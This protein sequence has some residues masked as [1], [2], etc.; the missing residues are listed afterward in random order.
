MKVSLNWIKEFVDLPADLSIQQLAYDLTMRTVEVEGF[1]DLGASLDKIVV[2]KIESVEPHP[3]QA[4]RLRVVKVDAGEDELCQV[5]CGGSNL[6]VGQMVVLAKPGSY[7]RWHGEGEPVEIKA[8]KL[9]GV[10]SAGMI[11]ASAEIGMEELFPAKEEAEIVDLA[12]YDATPGQP[13]SKLV[14]RDDI[15]LRLTTKHHQPSRFVGALWH[16][17]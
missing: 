13:V 7:V 2:A 5:V 8:S 10:P 3:P 6:E 17:A 12:G 15:I 4:D 11:C 14:G 16:R 1:E 9:R